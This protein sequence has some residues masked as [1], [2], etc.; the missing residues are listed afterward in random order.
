MVAKKLLRRDF[1]K[2]SGLALAGAPAVL[3]APRSGTFTT[4]LL[5]SGWWGMNIL[6]AALSSGRSEAV[7]LCDA[8]ESH[9]LPALDQV[10]EWTGKRPKAYRDYRELL[11]EEKPQIAIVASPDHWHALMALAAIESG[12]HVYLEKPIGHTILEGRAMLNAARSADRIVQVGTH[13]RVSPHNISAME[14]LRSGRAGQIG[15]VRAFV[16]YGGGPGQPQPDQEPPE[17]LDWDLWCGPAPKRPFNPS[18]HPRGFRQYLEYA[19]GLIG[20]WGIHWFDQ[21]LW[22]TEEKHPRKAYSTAARR[23]K[24]DGTNAPDAQV[25]TFDFDSFTLTWEHR[26]FSGNPNERHNIGCY[27]YGTNGVFHLGW[28]DGWTFY[29]SNQDDPV[30][31]EEPRLHEPDQQNIPELWHDFLDSIDRN[32]LPVCDIENG[33][34]AT[35]ISLLGM[36]SHRLGRSVEWDGEREIIPGDEQANAL[37]RREYR[38]PWEYPA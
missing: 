15:M 30:I 31:H 16:F 20:D 21:V 34:L 13:R 12:A 8:D 1:V 22:W 6:Q 9:L 38:Q 33:H 24:R 26:L 19:N 32:R 23:I 7:A 18:I 3:A 36:L 29:P 2:L 4:A 28:L 10:D 17:G 27:F 35:N 25:A 5:G 11:R 14:F 37:L